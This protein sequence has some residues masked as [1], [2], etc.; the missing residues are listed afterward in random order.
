MAQPQF[1]LPEFLENSSAEDIHERMM[2]N[3]P[4]D[5]DNMPG[6]FPYDM[7][8]P[9]ALEKDEIINFHIA[10]AL[11]IA[12]PEYAWDEWLDLHAR[13]V[14]LTRHEAKSAFGY[15][16][17]TATEGSE[18]LSGTVFCTAATETE[19]S[20]EYF[21][22]EDV[23]IG[24]EGFAM[25]PVSAAE[26]GTA[27][28]VIANTVVLMMVPDKNVT[29]VNNPEPIQGGTERETDDDFYDRI[30]TE[31]DNSMTYL[32]N[33]MDYI[34]WAKQAGAGDAIVIPAW[35]GPGTVKLVL[36]DGNGKP[37]NAKLVQ[38]VYNYIVSPDDRSAR[39]L[40]TGT[41][42]LTCTAATTIVVNYVITGLSYNETTNIEQIKKD[43]MEAVRTVYAQA[44]IEG[45]LR[46]NDVRPL[47]S[48]ITG[49]EDFE[50]FTMNDTIKNIIL[51]SE[52][53][54]DTGT[55]DFS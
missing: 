39:L 12:F 31:Y 24:S 44:K 5:I 22:T 43:F 45:V 34:R 7:T 55:L 10:R 42:E 9:A 54:P 50:I 23:I 35:N 19:P 40:P 11:M 2:N 32:G 1:Y 26:P 16:K 6:G 3:L 41:A 4:P 48:A 46:Y 27:A 37:A 52:E 15:V 49:V 30:A 53:Y 38:D 51:K 17:I 36:V 33:D 13:Q 14:H 47:I 28:N 25:V 8:M 29:E 18:I 21:A 20:I